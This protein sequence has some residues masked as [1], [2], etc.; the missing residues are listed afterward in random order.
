VFS[1]S[2]RCHP[3]RRTLSPTLRSLWCPASP[4]GCPASCVASS[5]CSKSHGRYVR[6]RAANIGVI[7]APH[8]TGARMSADASPC[9]QI[10]GLT[11]TTD[12]A[13]YLPMAPDYRRF[14][15]GWVAG[16]HCLHEQCMPNM[17]HADVPVSAGCTMEPWRI[18]SHSLYCP[19]VPPQEPT[20]QGHGSPRLAKAGVQHPLLWY[21][22]ADLSCCAWQPLP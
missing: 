2:P 3:L 7:A 14:A 9:L 8:R 13:E 4:A 16:R 19:S 17:A 18:E 1:A 21:A 11:S 10:T 5:R 6:L 20:S 15:P 12:Y 22:A